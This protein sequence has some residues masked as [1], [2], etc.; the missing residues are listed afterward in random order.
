VLLHVAD[1][2]R[3]RVGPQEDIVG[4]VKR[5]LD[6]PRWVFVGKVQRL[7]II[8]LEL[9]VGARRQTVAH[10]EENVLE[11]PEHLREDVA[12]PDR[13]VVRGSVA[14]KGGT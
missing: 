12:A 4:H 9:D 11:L 8:I 6:V 10:P 2:D 7:E 14:S 1:L 5:V 3:R 13:S